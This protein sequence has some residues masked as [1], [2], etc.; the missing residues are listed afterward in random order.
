M[1][2]LLEAEADT[3]S[4]LEAE[5]EAQWKLSASASLRIWAQ[6]SESRFFKK[7]HFLENRLMVA[8]NAVFGFWDFATNK[9]LQE[10]F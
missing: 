9:T 5:A 2:A 3:N 7:S 1:E 4:V 10:F 6:S 8:K